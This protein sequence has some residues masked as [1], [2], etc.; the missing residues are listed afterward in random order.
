MTNVSSARSTKKTYV[1]LA[2]EDKDSCALTSKENWE[3]NKKQLDLGE[4]GP[5]VLQKEFDAEDW[6]KAK[7]E[8]EKWL[9]TK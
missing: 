1:I 7:E 8:Y 3:K 6:E 2:N 9:T 5:L 4:N